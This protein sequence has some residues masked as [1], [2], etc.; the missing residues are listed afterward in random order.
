MHKAG[1]IKD[2]ITSSLINTVSLN[3]TWDP[4]MA[5]KLVKPVR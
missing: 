2:I 4:K 1:H 3:M 5:M